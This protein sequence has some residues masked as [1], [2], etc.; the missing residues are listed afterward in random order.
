[1]IINSPCKK[2]KGKNQNDPMRFV[3]NTTVTN[4]GEIAENFRIMKTEFQAR[5]VYLSREDRIQAHFLI[6]YLSLM[7]YRILEKKLKEKYTAE[8]IITTL[9]KMKLHIIPGTGYQPSYTRTD[10]TDE[11]HEIFGF[12]T[13]Y[14]IMTKSSIRNIIKLTKQRQ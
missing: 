9:R 6:C 8:K 10:L 14:Q 2:R 13:D 3:K 11:L 12:N 4:D 5:P 7:I 1:M